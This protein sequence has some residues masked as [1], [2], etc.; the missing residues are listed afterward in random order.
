MDEGGAA[1]LLLAFLWASENNLLTPVILED[2]GEDATINQIHHALKQKLVLSV[3]EEE[4]SDD[5]QGEEE[6][7]EAVGGRS[8]AL[9]ERLAR[10]PTIDRRGLGFMDDD[11]DEDDGPDPV[12][13]DGDE[14]LG[15]GLPRGNPPPADRFRELTM[16]TA[17]IVEVM[18]QVERARQKERK[19]DAQDKSLLK[20]LGKDQRNLFLRLSTH[21]LTAAPNLTE[22][23]KELSETTSATKALQ[24]VFSE[25]RDWDEPS[26]TAV[27]TDSFPQDLSLRSRTEQTR[28]VSTCSCSTPGQLTCQETSNSTRPKR[29]CATSSERKSTTTPSPTTPNKA[30]LPPQTITI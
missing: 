15:A 13:L 4:S 18:K 7:D 1:E 8:P 20:H 9:G 19:K 5:E 22:S 28:V 3:V 6:E 27:F 26:P 11:D 23:M 12:P 10:D 25:S 14:G 24:L 29:G 21:D 30:L 17:G 16:T 2:P